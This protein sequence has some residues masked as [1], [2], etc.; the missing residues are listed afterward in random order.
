[1]EMKLKDFPNIEEYLSLIDVSCNNMDELIADIIEIARLGKIENKNELLKTN[2]ILNL[3]RDLIKGKLSMDNIE[4]NIA[5]HLP[6]I[7][8]DR[9]RII[10]IFGNFLDNAIKYMGDQPNPIIS[11]ECEVNGDTNSFLIRDNGLGMDERALKKLFTPFERF[12]ANVKGTGL[13][14]YMVKQIA[15]SHGG[16][17]TAESEG[18]GKGTTFKL[19]LPRAEIAAQKA[20][21]TMNFQL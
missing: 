7:F 3:S 8:G 16:T 5:E 19:I 15:V 20:K 21:M 13:G 4:L 11:V 9:K 2:E 10:Q 6:Y 18:E 12:H 17:I 14:L 1:M